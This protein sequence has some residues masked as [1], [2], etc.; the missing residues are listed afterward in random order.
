MIAVDTS[1]LAAIAFREP[2]AAVFILALTEA[3]QICLSAGTVVETQMV[4]RGR[5]GDASV[6]GIDKL[7]SQLRAE[8]VA[9]DVAHVAVA[10]SA[11]RRFGKGTGHPAQLNF[12]DLFAYALAKSRGIPLL[13]KGE[14]FARTDIASVL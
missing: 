3:D 12:G 6:D 9:V 4:V 1:A 5:G 10:R 8:I 11:F 14:D 2:D 7:L 13:F